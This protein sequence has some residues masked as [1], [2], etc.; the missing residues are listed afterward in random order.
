MN[1]IAQHPGT[2]TAVLQL[3][4]QRLNRVLP[5]NPSER[6]PGSAPSSRHSPGTPPTM[7]SSP[8]RPTT[9]TSAATGPQR[10]ARER[11]PT[12]S[13]S[14]PPHSAAAPYAAPPISTSWFGPT[15]LTPRMAMYSF[16]PA[17][18]NSPISKFGCSHPTYAALTREW[19]AS[20]GSGLASRPARQ[21]SSGF[22]IRRSCEP[23]T[24]DK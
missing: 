16:A 9:P 10:S 14:P 22:L 21:A 1:Q 13:G 4:N 24:R 7:T 5:R 18:P 2:T 17:S 11:S 12:C 8:T 6:Q 15:W 3:W 23:P 20:A 19:P